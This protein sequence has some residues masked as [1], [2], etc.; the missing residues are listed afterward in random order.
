MIPVL[1]PTPDVALIEYVQE[2]CDAVADVQVEEVGLSPSIA[3]GKEGVTWSGDPCKM[4]PTMRLVD[5]ETGASWFVKPRLTIQV[6]ARVAKEDVLRGELVELMDGIVPI[7]DLRGASIPEGI[8]QATTP[9]R[10][11]TAVRRAHVQ[12]LPDAKRGDAVIVSVRRDSV[13]LTAEGE[14]LADARIGD[15]VQTL[16]HATH[17][18]LIGVLV[19]PHLVE[20]Q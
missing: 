14:L 12:H 11:G 6:H 16:N 19:S 3:L 20:I 17:A 10:K 4:A 9:I 2:S 18:T 7:Q 8:W 5:D 1:P 13:H 15:T